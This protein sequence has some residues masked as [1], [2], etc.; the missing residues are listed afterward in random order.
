[1]RCTPSNAKMFPGKGRR[2]NVPYRTTAPQLDKRGTAHGRLA[3]GRETLSYRFMTASPLRPQPDRSRDRRVEEFSNLWLVHP[4]SRAML[5]PALRAGISA[6]A[7]SCLGFGAG[8]AAA[9]C[10]YR[11]PDPVWV[12]AGIAL[13]VLWLALDGLD[14]MV[15]RATGTAGPLGRVMDGVC[16]HGSFILIYVALALS[17]GT[18]AGWL[19][20]VA[21]GTAHALQS[22]YYEGERARFH[23]RAAGRAPAPAPASPAGW[24]VNAYDRFAGAPDRAGATL[25]WTAAT[26]AEVAH[27]YARLATPP[28][29]LLTLLSAN[30]RVQLIALACLLG[31]PRLFWWAELFALTALAAFGYRLHRRAERRALGLPLAADP[32]ASLVFKDTS[33]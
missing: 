2:G 27:R 3:A 4:L 32:A 18:A 19:L 31:D 13:M 9:W 7:V 17:I 23:R 26:Q 25:D 5:R 21:A 11:Q 28:M 33:C 12:A 22:S 6:N 30:T 10:L 15:A 1:L 20:A 16:D 24:L 29:R 8:A 14:G